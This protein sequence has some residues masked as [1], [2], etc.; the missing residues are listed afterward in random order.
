M[1][2]FPFI[3]LVLENNYTYMVA[4]SNLSQILF[5]AVDILRL[6]T[7]QI[8]SKYSLRVF[9]SHVSHSNILVWKLLNKYVAKFEPKH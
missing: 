5:F 2:I 1:E 6:R 9:S 4:T 3:K 8:L 7:C